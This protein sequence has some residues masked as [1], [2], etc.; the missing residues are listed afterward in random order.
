MRLIAMDNGEDGDL[1]LAYIQNGGTVHVLIRDSVEEGD[2]LVPW[3]GAF[4]RAN[5]APVCVAGNAAKSG[6]SVAIRGLEPLTEAT[7]GERIREG[8]P[9]RLTG[10]TAWVVQ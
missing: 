5:T 4:G 9:L 7:A 8:Q 3:G 1:I 6:E 2:R 10:R